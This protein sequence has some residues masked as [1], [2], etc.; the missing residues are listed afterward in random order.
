MGADF[1]D[2]IFY[3]VDFQ[4]VQLSVATLTNASWNESI[5]PDGTN[6]GGG[7]FGGQGSCEGHF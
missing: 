7:V 1:T 5:C 3:Y 4:G 2:A 6:S